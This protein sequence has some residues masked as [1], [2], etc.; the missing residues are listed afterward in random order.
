MAPAIMLPRIAGSE[1]RIR[2]RLK[3][4]MPSHKSAAAMTVRKA[5]TVKTLTPAA[6]ATLAR[7]GTM[8]KKSGDN[9]P[10]SSPKF[11]WWLLLAKIVVSGLFFFA[12]TLAAGGLLDGVAMFLHTN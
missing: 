3:R 6:Y 1:L 8:P 2:F 4:T 11:H 5:T 10:Q 12:E 9:N 7:M